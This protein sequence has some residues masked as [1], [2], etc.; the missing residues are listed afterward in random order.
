MPASDS[1][2]SWVSVATAVCLAGSTLP[3]QPV[4]L[5]MAWLCLTGFVAYFWPT[6]FWALPT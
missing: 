6:P 1:F 2:Q 3:G 5:V 4:W